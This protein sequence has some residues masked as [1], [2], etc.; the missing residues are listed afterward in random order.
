MKIPRVIHYCW[1]GGK[2]LP[3][4]A[5]RCIESWRRY[6]PD[7]EIK[8]WNEENF[9]VNMLP[10]TAEAYVMR[11]YA[12]VSDV[13][14]LWI[15]YNHGGIYF[16]TDV[17]LVAPIDDILD[18]GP[19]LAYEAPDP[20]R[21]KLLVAMGLGMAC[22]PRNGV[23]KEFLDVYETRHHVSALGRFGGTIVAITTPVVERHMQEPVDGLH[24]CGNFTV[25]P[26]EYFCPLN[27]YTGEMNM[28]PH[29]RSIHHYASTWVDK[30]VETFWDKVRR[31]SRGIW[32][33]LVVKCT[34]LGKK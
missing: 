32:A 18:R 17:E 9:D 22:E 14:R 7:C 27:Y 12:F 31:R 13:A 1:F 21:G 5:V 16:D 19:F 24:Q 30:K 34:K 15:L 25:Y 23:V 4:E 10:Y 26:P 33:R 29:T 2:P 3:P 8:Q 6:M 28:T 11:Q 20:A